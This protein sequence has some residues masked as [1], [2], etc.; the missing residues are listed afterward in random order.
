M[1]P[2]A[3]MAAAPPPN[4][5]VVPLDARPH[6]TFGRAVHDDALIGVNP[7]PVLPAAAPPGW[8]RIGDTEQNQGPLR[9]RFAV[10]EVTLSRWLGATWIDEARKGFDPSPA[11]V[12]ELYGSWAPLPQLPAGT[13]APGSD[14]PT[15]QVKLWL[16]SKT[17]FDFSMHGGSAWDEWFTDTFHD[18]PCI[19]P[20]PERTICCKTRRH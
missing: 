8:E 6:L 7:Q 12:K 5:P 18:Y 2:S 4:A 10:R 13:A 3:D 1:L 9:A 20:A 17:P 11:G 14:P 15:A 19:P 16:W